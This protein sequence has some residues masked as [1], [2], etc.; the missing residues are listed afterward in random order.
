M[1]ARLD[2]Y[3]HSN[4]GKFFKHVNSCGCGHHR[5]DVARRHTRAGQDPS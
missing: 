3:S 5:F 1:D 4:V 2:L